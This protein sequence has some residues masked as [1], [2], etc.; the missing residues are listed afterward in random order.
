[1]GEKNERTQSRNIEPLVLSLHLCYCELKTKKCGKIMTMG[2]SP[3]NP[4]RGLTEQVY[5]LT[6][7]FKKQDIFTEAYMEKV[8][9]LES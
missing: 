1:M 2:F 5:L 8:K 7:L 9:V 6:F 4:K 3:F